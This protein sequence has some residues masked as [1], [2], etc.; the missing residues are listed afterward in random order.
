MRVFFTAAPNRTG[1]M[2]SGARNLIKHLSSNI[3]IFTFYE[4]P[5]CAKQTLEDDAFLLPDNVHLLKVSGVLNDLFSSKIFFLK[6]NLECAMASLKV[7][8]DI[9]HTLGYP[10][11]MYMK[12]LFKIRNPKAKHL[13]A[14]HGLSAT[15]RL[16]NVARSLIKDADI[17]TAVSRFDADMFFREYGKKCKVVYEGVDSDFFIPFEHDNE[18]LKILYVGRLTEYKNPMLIAKL[19][20]CFPE[21]DFIIHGRAGDATLRDKLVN[22]ASKTPNLTI[23][24]SYMTM[25]E[26]MFL[27]ASSDIFTFPS[28]EWFGL[29]TVEAMAC[30]LPVVGLNDGSTPEIVEDGKSGMLS[31]YLQIKENLN[32]LI[33]NDDVRRKMGRSA[34]IRA[35]WF[36]WERTAKEYE[37]LYEEVIS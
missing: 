20:K 22:Y 17:C 35:S 12:R 5:S 4:H 24:E 2:D 34:R 8:A 3:E 6:A 10:C 33:D 28:I 27:Y 7:D 25:K 11:H 23:D 21:C 14:S 29:V 26:M 15:S 37:K 9:V 13:Y 31:D 32:Y 30:G 36:T 19:A 18:R 1:P 16:K